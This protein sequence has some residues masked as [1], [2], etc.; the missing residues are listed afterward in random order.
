MANFLM[1]VGKPSAFEGNI[2]RVD[3]NASG[4]FYCNITS[5]TN[6]QHPILQRRIKTIQGMRT[7]AGLGSWTGW[8][9]SAEMDNAMKYG[10]TFVIIKGY[11]FKMENIFKTYVDTMYN[12]RL[13]YDKSH[14]MNLIAKLLMNSLYGKFAMK[15]EMTEVEIFDTS[16]EEGRKDMLEYLDIFNISIQDCVKIDNKALLIRN[17]MYALNYEEELDMFHGLDV[18]I[19]IASFITS[20]S[21]IVM[22]HFKNNPDFNLYYSDTDSIVIDTTLPEPMVGKSLGLVKLEHEI[23]KAVFIAPKVY[24]LVTEDGEEIIKIKG[25]SPDRIKENDISVN[26]LEQ[27]LIKDSEKEFSQEKWFKKVLEG[28]I[29]IEDKIYTLK[30]TSNKRRAIYFNENGIEIYKSTEPYFYNDN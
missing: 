21:R 1:P 9:T 24:G 7:I 17:T 23:N 11:E 15:L 30:T 20:Y 3:I 26:L 22:S 19:A 18:N 4:V 13:E 16:T 5:P 27:L 10:Y 8:I 25:F 12:L 29:R 14:A 6:L 28:Q 2:R